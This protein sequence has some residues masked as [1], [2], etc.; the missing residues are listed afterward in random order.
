VKT[1][2]FA[3][4]LAAAPAFAQHEHMQMP[5]QHDTVADFLMSQA[6]GTSANPGVAP[7]A[8]SMSQYRDWMLMVHGS[9]FISQVIETGPRGGDKL[10]STNW[11][12]GMADRK[13]GPGHLMLRSMLSL[14]PLTVRRSGYPELFQTGETLIDHQHPHDLFMELAAEYAVQVAAGTIGYVYAAPVGDP[15]LGPVAFPHRASAQEIPQATLSH[16]LQDSTHIASSVLTIGAKRDAFG[17]AVSGFHGR[18]PDQDRWDIDRGGIDSWS[19]RGTWDPSPNWS[20]QI[21]TGH[22]QNPESE[23]PGN[24]QRTTASAMYSTGAWSSSLIWGHNDKGGLHL[25]GVVLESNLRFNTSNYVSAR[26][27]VVD[28]DELVPGDVFTIKA[29]TVGYTKD[30][31]RTGDLLGGVGGNVT[32][33]A[34]PSAIRQTYGHRPLSFYA[35]VRIR[36]AGH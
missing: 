19:I 12:M 7:M 34:A 15:S 32:A 24:I 10:F 27:E 33:F 36:T 31:Y 20:A 16:H 3:I 25:N 11:I 6:S 28:K 18:E 13:L 5:M 8:M 35:F 17:L 1:Y 14:E 4:V 23:A 26:F 9:A 22:L 2:L 30:V 21:S 29:L